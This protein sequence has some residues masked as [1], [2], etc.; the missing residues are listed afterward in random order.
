MGSRFSLFSRFLKFGNDIRYCL[1]LHLHFKMIFETSIENN[2]DSL[3]REYLEAKNIFTEKP[4]KYALLQKGLV[5][6]LRKYGKFLLLDSDE[7]IIGYTND[8]DVGIAFQKSFNRMRINPRVLRKVTR[9]LFESLVVKESNLE[10]SEELMEFKNLFFG[11]PL[12]TSLDDEFI[13]LMRHILSK[14][15]RNTD[16]ERLRKMDVMCGERVFH[17]HLDALMGK[18]YGYFMRPNI[19]LEVEK[20]DALLI[21]TKVPL[22]STLFIGNSFVMDFTL[23]NSL[24]T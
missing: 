14:I 2:V 9:R 1:D 22:A 7:E 20:N 5:G 16:F 17:E 8:E 10:G 15:H 13:E 19:V 21:S 4:E 6:L 12:M 24:K 18:L 23:S 11:N 3:R